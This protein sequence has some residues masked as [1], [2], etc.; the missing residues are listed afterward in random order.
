[1]M[2]LDATSGGKKILVTS[3]VQT[4]GEQSISLCVHVLHVRKLNLTYTIWEHMLELV[5]LIVSP[6]TVSARNLAKK[7]V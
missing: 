1:M 5:C 6:F 2:L 7:I 3:N 4:D